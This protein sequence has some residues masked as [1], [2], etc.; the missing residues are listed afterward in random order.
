LDFVHDDRQPTPEQAFAARLREAREAHQMTQAELSRQLE[1]VHDLKIDPTSI[2]RM[3]NG[4]RMIRFNE[5]VALADILDIRVYDLIRP[6]SFMTTDQEGLREEAVRVQ[7]QLDDLNA[8]LAEAEKDLR[9]VRYSAAELREQRD[10]AEA[11]LASLRPSFGFTGRGWTGPM[12]ETRP[13]VAAIV[14]SVEGVLVGKRVDG[15]PPWTFI[16]GENEPDES[17][18]DTIVRE[19]KEE[20][21]LE[22]EADDTIGE[23]VH[24][25]TGRT[26]IYMA[27]HPVRGTSVFVGDEA[28]LD[29]VRWVSLDE[30]VELLPGMYEPVRNYLERTFGGRSR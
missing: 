19:V 20:T 26:M 21:G 16:A 30:A 1:A 23:R 9:S 10:R 3:E 8:K 27:G 13:I 28:E 6:E 4:K 5:A 2:A 29:A 17:P 14:T 18:A 24:P 25:Q 12:P 22:I 7:A 15:K 11:R